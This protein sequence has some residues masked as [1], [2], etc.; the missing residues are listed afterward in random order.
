MM[1]GNL[2]VS[3]ECDDDDAAAADDDDDFVSCDVIHR[4]GRKKPD[5]FKKFTKRRFLLVT[6]F[7][8]K[9]AGLWVGV[10]LTS[11]S[12]IAERPRCRWVS[13]GQ[14]WKTERQYLRTL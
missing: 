11:N 10:D 8:K 13:N 3:E 4:M 1:V 6:M 14:K 7:S 5:Y 12:A 2:P 9:I